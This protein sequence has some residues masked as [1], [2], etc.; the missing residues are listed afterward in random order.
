GTGFG[1]SICRRFV[2]ACGGE[3]TVRETELGAFTEF[4]M[5]LPRSN[6]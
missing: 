5:V 4:E 6:A 3:L 2:R 1:L